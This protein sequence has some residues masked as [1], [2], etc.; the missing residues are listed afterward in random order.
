MNLIDLF[1]TI[2]V[3]YVMIITTQQSLIDWDGNSICPKT[4]SHQVSKL[5]PY[6]ET[7]KKFWRYR[8]RTNYKWEYHTEWISEDA[9][10]NGYKEQSGECWPVCNGGDGCQHGLC[11]RPNQCNCDVGYKLV[12]VNQEQKCYPECSNCINGQCTAPNVCKCNDGYEKSLTGSDECRPSCKPRCPYMST[13]HEGNKCICM[14]G[15]TLA[16]VTVKLLPDSAD[17]RCKPVCS[18]EC[19]ENSFCLAPGVCMCNAG[20]EK[21]RV[22]GIKSS[23]ECVPYCETPCGDHSTCTKPDFCECNAGYAPLSNKDDDDQ[24]AS[25]NISANKCVPVCLP[26]CGEFGRCQSPNSCVCNQGY[27]LIL[28]H[29][30]KTSQTTVTCEPQCDPPC[31]IRG[32]CIA[33][34]SKCSCEIG[35]KLK[36]TIGKNLKN[37]SYCEPHCE[38]CPKFSVCTKPNECEC[39]HGYEKITD[40]LNITSCRP[41]CDKMCINGIC[42]TPNVCKCND[43]YILDTDDPF[44][45]EPNCGFPGCQGGHCTAPQ[46]CTC[47]DKYRPSKIK[48]VC[49]PICSQCDNGTCIAPELCICNDGFVKNSTDHCEP[50]CD[51][52]CFN[53]TCTAPFTCECDPGYTASNSTNSTSM[54]QP[55]C[56]SG[57]P[58]ATCIGPN[59]CLCI[60]GFIRN[61]NGDCIPDCNELCKFNNLTVGNC[62]APNQCTCYSGY[63][64]NNTT[65]SSE[66]CQ[67]LCTNSCVNGQCISPEVCKCNDGYIQDNLNGSICNPVCNIDCGY[68]D[69]LGPDQCVCH[70]GF[71][72]M[73]NTNFKNQTGPCVHPCQHECGYGKCNTDNQTC[74]CDYGW[75]GEYCNTTKLCGLIRTENDIDYHKWFA[76]KN[77]MNDTAGYLEA[78]KWQ[79]P[80]C[81][82]MCYSDDVNN[83]KKC[84][85]LSTDEEQFN[86]ATS[87]ICFINNAA[88][89]NLKQV[90]INNQLASG[91]TFG[92]IIFVVGI[93]SMIG[94]IHLI[95]RRRKIQD[96]KCNPQMVSADSSSRGNLLKQSELADSLLQFDEN[97]YL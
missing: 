68:G 28:G 32:S 6:T 41:V 49:D 97:S 38:S 36:H 5:V 52:K 87:I 9:C 16:N 75:T 26:S 20:Y 50:S 21:K 81:N 27:N 17:Y 62:I 53:G 46:V 35:W 63:V 1:I 90:S 11:I 84:F 56:Q 34:P 88:I 93:I 51:D 82:E 13:C 30:N 22:N 86:N 58:N 18:P 76:D 61:D 44:N 89:C 96:Y 60:D 39:H 14:H 4:V 94:V 33:P 92:I 66:Q 70:D 71:I 59:E 54:C 48:N 10:C 43:G 72:Q 40:N 67:P 24:L 12:T 73:N 25:T 7:Y 85:H 8:T 91:V 3:L 95:T 45:C 57:C 78:V 80:M 47:N 77:E 29:D 37:I 69:C 31:G 83:T 64:F 42:D 74:E 15:Y 55:F 19:D 2:I 23:N 65:E 79:G